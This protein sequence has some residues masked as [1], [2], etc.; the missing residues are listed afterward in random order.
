MVNVK[1]L[2]RKFDKIAAVSENTK[3]DIIELLGVKPE[4]ITVIYSGIENI[5][6]VMDKNDS[7]LKRV[8]EK[9]N[10]PEKFILF[11]GTVEPRKNIEGLIEAFNIL[12]EKGNDLSEFKL[13][14]AGGRGWKGENIYRE[15]QESKYREDIK[16]LGY[17]S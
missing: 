7:G 1:N 16:F 11:L 8:K 5:Y 12:R 14:I 6:K 9:Y 2:V 17:K 15:Q 3:N 13:V 4:K 10:L